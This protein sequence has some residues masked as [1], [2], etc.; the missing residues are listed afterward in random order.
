MAK[1]FLACVIGTD[2]GELTT[3]ARQAP[4]GIERCLENDR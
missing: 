4:F 3:Q 2:E 1:I